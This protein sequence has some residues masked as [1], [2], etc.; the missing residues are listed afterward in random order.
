M[1]N[2]KDG[3][4][5]LIEVDKKE[6]KKV[7]N[8]KIHTF[9]DTLKDD[10]DNKLYKVE[11]KKNQYFIKDKSG[12]EWHI[13]DHNGEQLLFNQKDKQVQ[14]LFQFIKQDLKLSYIQTHSFLQEKAQIKYIIRCNQDRAIF[15]QQ[16]LRMIQQKQILDLKGLN[17]ELSQYDR[18]ARIRL[19]AQR[20][21]ELRNVDLNTPYSISIN[22]IKHEIEEMIP[23]SVINSMKEEMAKNRD[24]KAKEQ[25]SLDELLNTDLYL[26]QTF[27]IDLNDDPRSRSHKFH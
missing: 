21:S 13:M 3:F 23:K 4:D 24:I 14:T 6:A 9:L 19:E 11:E 12:K 7:L 1:S 27:D 8:T 17:A 16:I 20:E 18:H 5:K 25:K 15:Q 10:K 26:N 2:F 22:N